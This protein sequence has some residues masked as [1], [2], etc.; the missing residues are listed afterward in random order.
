MT[1]T[2]P[3]RLTIGLTG[4]IGSGKSTVS[5]MLVELGAEE[6]EDLFDSAIGVWQE[7]DMLAFLARTIALAHQLRGPAPADC[8]VFIP[9]WWW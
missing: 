7:D 6:A 5:Q 1:V 9:M 8:Q 4:G 3:A 2:T